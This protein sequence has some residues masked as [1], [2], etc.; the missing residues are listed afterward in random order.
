MRSAAHQP[1]P[2]LGAVVRVRVGLL[3]VLARRAFIVGE[4]L[5][6][7]YKRGSCREQWVDS[8]GFAPEDAPPCEGSD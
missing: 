7:Y 6:W 4:E 8:H 2:L 5:R 1:R 3:L